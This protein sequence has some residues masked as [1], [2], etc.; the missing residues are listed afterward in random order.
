MHILIV[1]QSKIPAEKYGGTQRVIWGLGKA[2][3]QAGH[4]V[5]FMAA[6]GSVCEFATNMLVLNKQQSFEVQVPEFADVVHYNG[7]PPGG[8]QIQKPFISTLHGNINYACRLH[9]NT[10]FISADHARR[11]GG[12]VFVYNGL[13]WSNYGS[14]GNFA[15]HPGK[16]FHFLANA[17]WKVKNVKGAIRITRM[18]KE[19]LAVLG[20][21][22]INFNMGFR[23]TPDMHVSFKGKVT[24]AQK[25]FFLLQSKGLLFPVLWHEPF[26][27]AIIESLYFGCPVFATPYGS[28]PELV[29]AEVGFLSNSE[30]TLAAA[31]KNASAYSPAQCH[32]YAA[33]LFNAALM[34]K[35][36]IALYEKV[37][38]GAFL[39]DTEPLVKQANI[40]NK[41]YLE[42]L[43]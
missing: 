22:R 39:H 36:Y 24:D 20:G 5:S 40:G 30:S 43:P 32:A 1:T 23:F 6:E 25:Q 16:Y 38:G 33:D 11:H 9:R 8:D 26:G 12:E 7:I 27:L 42:M 41:K 15:N 37:L 18:A 35:G 14:P 29:P 3:V 13:D 17:S 28:L 19:K 4:K 31:L 34:A 2:L 21:S 10:V